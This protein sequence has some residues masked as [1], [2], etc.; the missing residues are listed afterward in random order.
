M[1]ISAKDVVEDMKLYMSGKPLSVGA[2]RGGRGEHIP[3]P[4]QEPAPE[5]PLLPNGYRDY[6]KYYGF[7][8][9]FYTLIVFMLNTHLF[10]RL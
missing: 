6:C 7:V 10:D 2:V 1:R 5:P 8:S 4:P 9:L 3:P